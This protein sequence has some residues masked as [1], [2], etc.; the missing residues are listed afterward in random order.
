[1]LLVRRSFVSFDLCYW[2]GWQDALQQRRLVRG[3][4]W[5][6]DPYHFILVLIR[7]PRNQ[8]WI[9][10]SI[11]GTNWYVEWHLAIHLAVV[12]AVESQTVSAYFV[13]CIHTH[14][15][16]T[17]GNTRSPLECNQHATKMIKKFALTVS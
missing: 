10:L 6:C 15:M 12:A 14:D 3:R 16:C 7:H 17:D 13:F 9:A 5:E 11:L 2:F 8:P 1:M 4:S